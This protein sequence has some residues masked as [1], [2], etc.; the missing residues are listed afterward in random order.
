[1][2]SDSPE[3][4]VVDLSKL[5]EALSVGDLDVLVGLLEDEWLEAKSGKYD[6]QNDSGRAELA[7]DVSSF[8]NRIGGLIVIGAQTSDN[9]TIA[10]RRIESVSPFSVDLIDPAQYH[11]VMNSWIY[12]QVDNVVIEWKRSRLKPSL[13]VLTIFIPP[14]AEHSKPF[15]LKKDIDPST[16]YRRKGILFGLVERL[17]HS[18]KPSSIDRVHS[19]IKMGR[20]NSLLQQVLERLSAIESNLPPSQEQLERS[21]GLV[22][23][24]TSRVTIAAKA[25]SLFHVPNFHIAITP[26]QI[27]E[28]QSLFDATTSGIRSRLENPRRLRSAGW[29]MYTA[30]DAELVGGKLLRVKSQ[31]YKIIDLYRDGTLVFV[32][33]AGEQLLCYGS[34]FHDGKINPLALI[35]TTYMFCDLYADVLNHLSIPPQ[36]LRLQIG[37]SHAK[38]DQLTYALPPGDVASAAIAHTMS[39]HPAPSDAWSIPIDVQVAG[40]TPAKIGFIAISELYA[41]FGMSLQDIPYLTKARDA[42]DEESLKNP[43]M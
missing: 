6:L 31:E 17:S 24:V 23:I 18:S 1:M 26:V 33:T 8:A 27:T 9:A 3:N 13:G 38:S 14:Q 5:R 15:L 28:V 34:S 25:A 12:P 11:D 20:E 39:M 7:K 29:N 41:S 43:R 2:N 16:N 21:R 30:S 19:L 22:A 36:S 35:E 32:C 37:F 10:G 42:I 4:P 40:F